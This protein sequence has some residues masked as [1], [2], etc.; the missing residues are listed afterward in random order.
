MDTRTGS[1][2]NRRFLN[3]RLVLSI[4]PKLGRPLSGF[5]SILCLLLYLACMEGWKWR[6]GQ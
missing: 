6:K 4:V 2:N 1:T 3:L 5:A